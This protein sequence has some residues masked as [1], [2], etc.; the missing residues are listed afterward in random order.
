M[1]EKAARHAADAAEKGEL[2]KV[3]VLLHAVA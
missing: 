2:G 3:K 1:A